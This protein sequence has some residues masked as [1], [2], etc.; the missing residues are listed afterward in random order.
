MAHHERLADHYLTDWRRSGP[1]R[2]I[3]SRATVTTA[4]GGTRTDAIRT[5]MRRL[6][7]AS[8]RHVSAAG[9]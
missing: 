1:R 6:A 7:T 3:G 5:V 4:P 8:S 2:G 9:S